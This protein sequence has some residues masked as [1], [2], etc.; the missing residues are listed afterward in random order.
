MPD[1]T[2]QTFFHPPGFV[3]VL[4]KHC[5]NTEKSQLINVNAR[6]S[7]VK[8]FNLSKLAFFS[9][10]KVN[11]AN[12]WQIWRIV[13]TRDIYGMS[14]FCRKIWRPVPSLKNKKFLVKSPENMLNYIKGAVGLNCF[15]S[16]VKNKQKTSFLLPFWWCH[17][18]WNRYI[19]SCTCSTHIKLTFEG[20]RID[21]R[22]FGSTMTSGK[23]CRARKQ[24]S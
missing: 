3:S 15:S 2:S 20:R 16:L 23:I 5:F 21:P 22:L 13:T 8:N 17:Q 9:F 4:E 10:A 18:N 14:K 12:L 6:S 24:G 11:S 19:S 7:V 1:L